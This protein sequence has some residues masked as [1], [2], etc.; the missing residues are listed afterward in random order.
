METFWVSVCFF[1]L[2]HGYIWHD[3]FPYDTFV[4]VPI[5]HIPLADSVCIFNVCSLKTI[6][7]MPSR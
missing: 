7:A 5:H 3:T 6:Y 4:D 2:F 1:D